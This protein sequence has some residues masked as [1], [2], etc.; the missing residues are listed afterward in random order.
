[1]YNKLTGGVMDK[2]KFGEFIYQKRKKLGLTQ[3]ELG[4][5]TRCH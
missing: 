1:M 2:Y 5:K 4:K 3:E